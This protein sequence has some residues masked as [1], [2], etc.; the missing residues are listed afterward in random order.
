MTTPEQPSDHTI[1]YRTSIEAETG[2]LVEIN[3]TIPHNLVVSLAASPDN[4]EPGVSELAG[5]LARE[6]FNH[7][8]TAGRD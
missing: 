2:L 7:I 8:A 3:V 6:L 5:I 1:T 4:I